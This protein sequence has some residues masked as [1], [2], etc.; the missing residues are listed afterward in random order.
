MFVGGVVPVRTQINL[1]VGRM[2]VITDRHRHQ[3]G[4][5]FLRR[6]S[7]MEAT[8]SNLEDLQTETLPQSP[9]VVDRPRMWSGRH[10]L[11][12]MEVPLCLIR[13]VECFTNPSAISST[14]PKRSFTLAT[15]SK[16]TL[17]TSLES[18]QPFNQLIPRQ[19]KAKL[20]QMIPVVQ[21]LRR[22]RRM[23]QVV[24]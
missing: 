5:S 2:K 15:R 12:I 10:C 7:I 14:I 11:K 22:Q 4:M 17:C 21:P 9:L 19:G 18:R 16:N 1:V 8:T 3:Q 23:H 20:S 6:D 13:G 24:E